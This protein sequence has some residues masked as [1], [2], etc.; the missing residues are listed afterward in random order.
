[1]QGLGN[2]GFHAARLL[3]E[4]DECLITGLLERDGALVNPE[5]LDIESIRNYIV[6]QGSIK[7]Y[8]DATFVTDGMSVLEMDC[9]I[10]I[11]A[12]M[13]AQITLVE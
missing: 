5:G 7:G 3:Q 1:M 10:L 12:A 6:E 11:P 9:D 4:E 13:E 8:P 2:V